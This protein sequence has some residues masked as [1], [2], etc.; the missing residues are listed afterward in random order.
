[1]RGRGWRLGAGCKRPRSCIERRSELL[2]PAQKLIRELG[3]NEYSRPSEETI[4]KAW[5]AQNGG[6]VPVAMARDIENTIR[7]CHNIIQ[8]LERIKEI[9]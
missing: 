2:D 3:L 4:L 9:T 1:M 8:K 7:E 5:K 6:R